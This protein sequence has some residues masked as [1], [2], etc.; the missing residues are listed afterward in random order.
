[1]RRFF[2]GRF[3]LAEP[4]RLTWKGQI[5]ELSWKAWELV[6]AAFDHHV[7]SDDALFES[8][9]ATQTALDQA[10]AVAQAES[11][12]FAFPL[13]MRRELVR[14]FRKDWAAGRIANVAGWCF[15]QGISPRTLQRYR[16]EFGGDVP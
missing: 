4:G 9:W 14:M 7:T 15:A 2:K 10:Q 6:R 8:L 1:M 12:H 13:E 11:R 3:K 5:L 16:D